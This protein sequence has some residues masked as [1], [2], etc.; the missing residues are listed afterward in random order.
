MVHTGDVDVEVL[1]TQFN[2]WKREQTTQ[3]MLQEGSVRL[4]IEERPE[5]IVMQPGELVEFSRGS[6]QLVQRVVDP[7]QYGSWKEH[8]LIL[9]ERP[10]VELTDKIKE[11][12]GRRVVVDTRLQ[13]IKLTGT[14][15]TNN[16]DDLLELLSASTGLQVEIK[17][18]E[19]FLHR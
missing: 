17:Q 7:Q 3:V 4:R 13:Q 16:L 6:L 2:V 1:G 19:I 12:Y 5:E 10:L 9:T 15:P 8:Q 14:F 11:I 18:D